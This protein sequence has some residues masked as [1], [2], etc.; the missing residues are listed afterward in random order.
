MPATREAFIVAAIDDIDAKMNI[1]DKAYRG[2][3]PGGLTTKLYNMDD[4]YFYKATF[5]EENKD[6]GLTLEEL[7]ADLLKGKK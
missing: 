1:L 3:E 5:L 7:K 6:P 2:V 4:R